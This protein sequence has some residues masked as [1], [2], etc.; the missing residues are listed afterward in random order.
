MNCKHCDTSIN[1]IRER[2]TQRCG[3]CIYQL[4]PKHS[5]KQL[6]RFGL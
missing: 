6:R 1:S 3:K 5:K 2:L 4:Q